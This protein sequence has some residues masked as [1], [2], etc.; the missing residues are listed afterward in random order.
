MAAPSANLFGHTS[1]TTAAHVLD[2]LDGRID[3]ILDA[4]PTRHGVES[5]VLDPCQSPMRDLPPRRYHGCPDSK[6]SRPR[7]AL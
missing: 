4:G 6:H 2:D 5:T 3:A 7:R 1:P